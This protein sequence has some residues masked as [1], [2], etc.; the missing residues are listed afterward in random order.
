VSLNGEP[1]ADDIIE[2]GDGSRNARQPGL[3]TPRWLGFL[4]PASGVERPG[5]RLSRGAAVLAAVALLAGLGAGYA[6]GKGSRGAAPTPARTSPAIVV[7]TPSAPANPLA[8]VGPPIEQFPESCSAQTGSEL[9]VGVEVE[10]DSATAVNLVG[11]KTT[12]PASNGVLREVSWMWEPCGAISYG[13]YQSTVDLQ[14]GASAWLS[15]TLKVNV[16]CPEPYPVQF[17]VTYIRGGTAGT[18][19]L[20]GF[21]DLGSVPYNDC[22]AQGVTATGYSSAWSTT[23]DRAVTVDH[24]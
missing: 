4:G 14:P 3:E 17:S 23:D 19:Q 7:T 5:Q 18:A 24:W 11:V 9:Q 2:R 21:P 15:V 12:F 13:L 6:A 10:N 16:P 20:P 8:D 1:D 22:A